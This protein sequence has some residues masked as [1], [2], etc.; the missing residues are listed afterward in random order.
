MPQV[1]ETCFLARLLHG[2]A[3]LVLGQRTCT[4]YIYTV[5]LDLIFLVYVHIDDYTVVTCHVGALYHIHLGI[6]IT[7][8]IVVVLDNLGGAVNDIRC[9]LITLDDTDFHLQILPV[10]LLHTENIQL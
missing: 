7:L 1:I 6:L 2:I 8:L 5:Y 3:H 10:R 4:L 9:N